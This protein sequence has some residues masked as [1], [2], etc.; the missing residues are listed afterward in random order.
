M[1]VIAG[2]AR[3]LRLKAPPGTV[4]RPTADRVKQSLFG[5]LG[6]RVEGARVLDLFAGSGSLGIEALSRGAATAVFVERSRPCVQVIR[7]NLTRTRFLEQAEV[8][9]G[10]ALAAVGRFAAQQRKF[11]IIF[12]DPP[13]EGGLA[14]AV[15]EAVAE[16]SLLTEKGLLVVEH[17]RREEIPQEKANLRAERHRVYG[18]T[19]ITIFS[20]TGS[21]GADEGGG[22]A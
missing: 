7:E 19:A 9:V 13:Y 18:D 15:V 11:D 5:M 14:A 10:D 22:V 20:A 17:D 2:K 8:V 16:A 4:A 1:R 3:G 21:S 6:S 12:A